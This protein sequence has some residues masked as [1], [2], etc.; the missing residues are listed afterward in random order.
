MPNS[1]ATRLAEI[2]NDGYTIIEDAMSADLMARIREELDPSVRAK[3]RA[4]TILKAP[5][6][7]E[8]MRCLQKHPQLPR[9]SSTQQRW[10]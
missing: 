5:T 4:A 6:Q 9:S 3:T 2:E 7:N 1:T 10:R 8:S